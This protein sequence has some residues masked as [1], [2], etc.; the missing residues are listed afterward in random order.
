MW[1]KI[2]YRNYECPSVCWNPAAN[3]GPIY[4]GGIPWQPSS[5]QDNDPKHVP[6]LGQQ[7]FKDKKITWWKTPPESPDLNPIENLWYELSEER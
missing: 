7:F 4:Q 5:N 1:Y 2:I 6:K 3:T